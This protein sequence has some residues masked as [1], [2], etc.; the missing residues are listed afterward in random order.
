MMN[1]FYCNAEVVMTSAFF[2]LFNDLVFVNS[3]TYTVDFYTAIIEECSTFTTHR[4]VSF[5]SSLNFR[6]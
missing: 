4:I 2:T 5:H 3:F 6:V 1:L